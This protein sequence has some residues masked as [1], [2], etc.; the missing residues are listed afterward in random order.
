M[1][2]FSFKEA[3]IGRETYEKKLGMFGQIVFYFGKIIIPPP[4]RDAPLTVGRLIGRLQA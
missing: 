3:F 2:K 4:G 1:T